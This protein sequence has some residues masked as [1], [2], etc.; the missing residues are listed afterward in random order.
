[1]TTFYYHSYRVYWKLMKINQWK[2]IWKTTY[3]YCWNF[4]GFYIFNTIRATPLGCKFIGLLVA[5]KY[6]ENHLRTR[7]NYLDQPGFNW[8]SGYI[9]KT[10]KDHISSRKK[11]KNNWELSLPFKYVAYISAFLSIFS[12]CSL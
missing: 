11:L 4:T 3:Y 1:M 7:E 6:H 10:Q 2:E 8:L 9:L 12:K 5:V